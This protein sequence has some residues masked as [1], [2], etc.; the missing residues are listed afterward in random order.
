MQ[1]RERDG[2]HGH[3]AGTGD[4]PAKDALL[5][6]QCHPALLAL[7]VLIPGLILLGW[8]T[9]WPLL[10]RAALSQLLSHEEDSSM[11]TSGWA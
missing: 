11:E 2:C 10:L 6:L 7:T 3:P 9:A 4:I 8:K 1:P 5:S